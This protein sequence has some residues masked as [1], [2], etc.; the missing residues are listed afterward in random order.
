MKLC[1][2]SLSDQPIAVISGDQSKGVAA[3]RA[4]WVN[5]IGVFI[6]ILISSIA[7]GSPV[8]AYAATLQATKATNLAWAD[9]QIKLS[10][11]EVSFWT[12][13]LR[14]VSTRLAKDLSAG[15][16]RTRQSLVKLDN[17]KLMLD[18]LAEDPQL[19]SSPLRSELEGYRL[20]IASRKQQVASEWEA[21]REAVTA[22]TLRRPQL[23]LANRETYLS[24][25]AVYKVR[26]TAAAT[27]AELAKIS[28]P[29]LIPSPNASPQM[30]ADSS[31]KNSAQVEALDDRIFAI[32]KLAKLD[33]S[34]GTCMVPASDDEHHGDEDDH[35]TGHHGTCGCEDGVVTVHGQK[36]VLPKTTRVISGNTKMSDI[37]ADVGTEEVIEIDHDATLVYDVSSDTKLKAMVVYGNL[38]FA[39]DRN[40]K[41]LVN[42]LIVAPPG[43]LTVGSE[44]APIGDDYTA[45]IVIAEYP[46]DRVNDPYQLAGTL[47]GLGKVEM[48]GRRVATPGIAP[49][50]S[51]K[52]GESSIVLGQLP[53][54][55][56]WRVGDTIVLADTRPL[57]QIRLKVYESQTEYATIS[58]IN[59]NR[60]DF[61][62]PLKYDHPAIMLPGIDGKLSIAKQI[63]VVDTSRNVQIRSEKPLGIRGHTMFADQ[64]N[65]N[66]QNVAFK[67]LGR[68]RAGDLDNTECD[69]Q[70]RLQNY[71]DNQIGRYALHLH[72]LRGPNNPTN[73]GYQFKLVGAAF[74]GSLRWAAAIHQ[75]SYGLISDN[76]FHNNPGT[77]LAFEDGHEAYNEVIRNWFIGTAPGFET[78]P[79][80]EPQRG[81]RV[82]DPRTQSL[83]FHGRIAIWDAPLNT[84]K[85]NRIYGHFSVGYQ[86][87]HYYA[88]D[89]K[90]PKFR[91]ADINDPS[92]VI[93][94]AARRNDA[95]NRTSAIP[96]GEKENNVIFGSLIAFYQAWDRAT[97]TRSAYAENPAIYKRFIIANAQQ[98]VKAYHTAYSQY[99]DFVMVNDPKVANQYDGLARYSVGFN[100]ANPSY[101][102][103]HTK[104]VSD[105]ATAVVASSEGAADADGIY[106]GTYVVNFH[107]GADLARNADLFGVVGN[108]ENITT[109][110]GGF[111]QNYVNLKINTATDKTPRVAVIS[112]VALFSPAE[113][114][115]IPGFPQRS[116]SVMMN[117]GLGSRG[118]YAHLLTRDRVLISRWSMNG[119]SAPN[120]GVYYLQQRPDF[121]V[122]VSSDVIPRVVG[123]IEPNLTNEQHRLK[124]GTSIADAIAP[125]DR[126]GVS[127]ETLRSQ[128]EQWGIYG[129]VEQQD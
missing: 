44:Q 117:Y 116:L 60:V 106:A 102:S 51:P 73:T 91:G 33:L 7:C 36:M 122:P 2:L 41:L 72:F 13:N 55:S 11:G 32:R 29:K 34:Q 26:V 61:D 109:V 31:V 114:K 81:G 53:A 56:G 1:G 108:Q 62:N 49:V 121:V 64:A 24:Q 47:L 95:N 39:T 28:R 14:T 123:A 85:D 48:Y 4:N 17:L 27:S 77:A 93:R 80:D 98:G 69:S 113:M 111:W 100:L 82:R 59:G 35:P 88:K 70:G 120:M 5:T 30:P 22:L 92:S 105:N 9:N 8:K 96:V 94:W 67:D 6:A 74:E 125:C 16:E 19:V 10:R 54:E 38:T 112:D 79:E 87:N 118:T 84:F 103:A 42:N 50:A 110:T 43:S 89:F 127:C 83:T 99:H 45:Q 65:I 97:A 25:L 124:Y 3:S 86:N 18:L 107:I 104:I 71:G 119:V 90:T 126:G 78:V 101:E 75:S 57:A 37:I 68:S 23:N 63:E 40:T 12:E 115:Q 128:G 76:V 129:L 20:S 15:G 52:A 46:L 58:A 66:I 21:Y